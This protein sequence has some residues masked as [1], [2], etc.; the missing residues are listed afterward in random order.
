MK[1]FSKWPGLALFAAFGLQATAWADV[2]ALPEQI[3]QV[4]VDQTLAQVQAALGRP[5]TDRRYALG[6][7]RVWTYVI[8]GGRE[9]LEVS[10][11]PDSRVVAVRAAALSS[12]P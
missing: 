2:T 5:A 7:T 11:G 9:E 12:V 3:A 8:P 4:K 1:Q 10:F 6:S